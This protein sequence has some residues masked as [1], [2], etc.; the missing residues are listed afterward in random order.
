MVL[1]RGLPLYLDVLKREKQK[2]KILP[3]WRRGPTFKPETKS[4]GLKTPALRLNLKRSAD[5][6]SFRNRLRR[7]VSLIKDGLR[8]YFV[9]ALL[10]S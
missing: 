10:V 7:E 5:L 2:Q 3:R 8:G 9:P 1:V 6:Q 4:A